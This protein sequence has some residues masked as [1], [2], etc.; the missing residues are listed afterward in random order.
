MRLAWSVLCVSL[1]FSLWAGTASGQDFR[2]ESKVVITRKVAAERM[3]RQV[4]SQ[5]PQVI[6]AS[7]TVFHAGRGYDYLP[8][9]D[10]LT[11]YD[12][13]H[14]RF[15][16]ISRPNRVACRLT[17]T[18]IE[19]ELHRIDNTT[20]QH[21][22]ELPEPK[23]PAEITLRKRSQF[24]LKP[25]FSA[26]QTGDQLLLESDVVTYRVACDAAK[27]DEHLAVCIG[28]ADWFARLNA[29]VNRNAPL[30]WARLKLNAELQSRRVLPTMIEQ[31]WTNDGTTVQARHTY[32]WT[33]N[34]GDRKKI[35]EYEEIA[36]DTELTW[37]PLAQYL[38]Q[39]GIV[40]D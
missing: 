3:V 11:I 5:S 19:T 7:S 4:S 17:F 31:A 24:L 21:L 1:V 35:R 33:L 39:I 2:V 28:Y 29:V 12:A 27:S 14:Q 34:T 30:P 13:A 22:A 6:S 26:S 9:V 8:D 25:S 38:R 18:D 23:T 32:H 15:L 10:E 36:N 16:L 40:K 37:V 20:S